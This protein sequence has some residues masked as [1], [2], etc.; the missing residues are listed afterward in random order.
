MFFG[1]Y[2][3]VKHTVRIKGEQH[4]L[5]DVVGKD[6]VL[7]HYQVT[8]DASSMQPQYVAQTRL[9]LGSMWSTISHEVEV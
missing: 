7:F 4:E 6:A 2:P 5:Y 3:V 1:F 8:E 9:W